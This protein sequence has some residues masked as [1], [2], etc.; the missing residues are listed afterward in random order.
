MI[1]QLKD[2]IRVLDGIAPFPMAEEWDNPGF[3]VGFLTDEI[4]KAL[5]SLDPTIKALKNAIEINAQLLITHHPLIFDHLTSINPETYPGDVI[6]EALKSRVSIVA[7]H[8]NL[9]MAK[10][11][12][13]DILARMIGLQ[14]T[15][16]LL[17]KD[18]SKDKFNGLGRIG[19]LPEAMSL[20]SAARI[21]MDA[22]GSTGLM[23]MGSSGREVKKVAILGGSGGSELSSA[24][25]K[26]ADLY[27]TGDIRHHEALLAQTLGLALI[28]AGH[29]NMERA[30]MHVFGDHLRDKFKDLGWD[31]VIEIFE[32][33][34]APM[35]YMARED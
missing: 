8:T 11:G 25:E 23:V 17:Q 30:A 21:I 33:E 27:I 19:Y 5:I 15:E 18:D 12:I 16:A 24:S 2:I 31:L 22:I 34:K 29:F 4:K 9:D 13:N 35:R 32:D 1:K 3:Q 7:V 6:S 28:D 20:A 14:N 26:G 10:D